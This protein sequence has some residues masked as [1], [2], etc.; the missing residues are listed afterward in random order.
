MDFLK[1]VIIVVAIIVILTSLYTFSIGIIQND[2]PVT[3]ISV[4]NFVLGF[5][6]IY[7]AKKRK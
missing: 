2:F 1:N 5:V 3:F 6:N 4:V 7:F